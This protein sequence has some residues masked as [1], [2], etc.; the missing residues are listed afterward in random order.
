MGV[1]ISTWFNAN[2]VL[3]YPPFPGGN[4]PF[5]C[6]KFEPKDR[7]LEKAKIIHLY[8]TAIWNTISHMAPNRSLQMVYYMPIPRPAIKT[9]TLNETIQVASCRSKEGLTLN[10]MPYKSSGQ[11]PTFG[12]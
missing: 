4:I 3:M 2:A 6:R 10:S 5:S 7:L 9:N 12:E 8:G 1:P 11:I